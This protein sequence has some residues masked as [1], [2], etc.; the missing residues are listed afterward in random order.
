[1]RDLFFRLNSRGETMDIST[2]SKASKQR[3]AQGFEIILTKAIQELRAKKGERKDKDWVLFPL[4]S[5][6]INK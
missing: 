2:F 5:T 6:V 4:D 1:M 3:D